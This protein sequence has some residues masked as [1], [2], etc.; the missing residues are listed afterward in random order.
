LFSEPTVNLNDALTAAHRGSLDAVKQYLAEGGAL[1]AKNEAGFTLLLVALEGRQPRLAQW[2]LDQ[3]ADARARL[4]SGFSALHVL[5]K[6][7]RNLPTQLQVQVERDGKQVTLTDPE[8]IRGVLGTHP[9]DEL[10]ELLACAA[11]ILEKGFEIEATS[12]SKKSP[13]LRYAAEVSEPLALL[14]LERAAPDVNAADTEGFTAL[15]M[16]AR[17]GSSALARALLD[18][19]ARVD[20]P[21]TLGFT[22]LHEALMAG[23]A[24]LAALLL[25]RGA[26]PSRALTG[27]YAAY[28]PGDTAVEIVK[29]SHPELLPVLA[30]ARP[31]PPPAR[32]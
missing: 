27:G 24:E 23:K 12:G 9:D 20:A 26:S 22:P 4:T 30:Q 1:E 11:K 3:G 10:Q 8:E 21:D 31:A 13:P 28:A 16:A 6:H 17:L 5:T 15:H 18:R 29:K 25:E 14:L 19:G 32:P 2:L 7:F